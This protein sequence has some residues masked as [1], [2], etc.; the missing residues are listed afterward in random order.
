M[1]EIQKR[2]SFAPI[3]LHNLYCTDDYYWCLSSQTQF[4][5]HW[6]QIEWTFIMIVRPRCIYHLPSSQSCKGQK[7]PLVQNSRS[8]FTCHSYKCTNAVCSQDWL[9]DVVCLHLREACLVF[10]LCFCS[11]IHQQCF[12]SDDSVYLSN[13]SGTLKKKSPTI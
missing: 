5:Y 9:M 13:N 8:M 12:V 6:V 4:S 7:N 2:Q 11:L 1:E 10:S 3:Q